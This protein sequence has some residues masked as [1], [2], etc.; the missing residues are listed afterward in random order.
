MS[1]WTIDTNIALSNGAINTT[2]SH[3]YSVLCSGDTFILQQSRTPSSSLASGSEG[4][5]CFDSSFLYIYRSNRWGR[6]PVDT[7]F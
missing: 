2:S 5:M 4:E 7:N 3:P 6:I 1:T